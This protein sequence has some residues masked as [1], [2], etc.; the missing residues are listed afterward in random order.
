[1][2]NRHNF[3]SYSF[4]ALVFTLL[5]SLNANSQ[6]PHATDVD[7]KAAYCYPTVKYEHEQYNKLT[8]RYPSPSSSNEIKNI[9]EAG[10]VYNNKLQIYLRARNQSHNIEARNEVLAAISAGEQ[11]LNVMKKI[12]DTCSSQVDFKNLNTDQALEKIQS[13]WKTNGSAMLKLE[14]CNNL[15]FLPY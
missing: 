3:F 6:G 13:C 4:C 11:A 5:F 14:I 2:K 15:S 9:N 8:E 7:L 1:M 10:V 12:K